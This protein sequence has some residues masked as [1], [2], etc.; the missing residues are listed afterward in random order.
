M[1]M[2]LDNNTG[3]SDVAG[4]WTSNGS[5]LEVGCQYGW[6]YEDA[7][8]EAT[9]TMEVCMLSVDHKNM[10]MVA[11]LLRLIFSLLSLHSSEF[12]P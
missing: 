6:V 11:Y 5:L 3:V 7:D 9:I 4:P 8:I 12:S 1:Y 2:G 10:L